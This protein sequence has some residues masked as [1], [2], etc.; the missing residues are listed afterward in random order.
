MGT[1]HHQPATRIVADLLRDENDP[2]IR[3]DLLFL[4]VWRTNRPDGIAAVLRAGQ[5]R[6]ANPDLLAA[7]EREQ[8]GARGG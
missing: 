8:T 1:A 6:R 2:L 4:E 5:L 7:I 3:A